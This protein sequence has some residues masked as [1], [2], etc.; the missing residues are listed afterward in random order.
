MHPLDTTANAAPSSPEQNDPNDQQE[1][2]EIR[3]ILK[4]VYDEI[5]RRLPEGRHK[6]LALT[7]I[8]TASLWAVKAIFHR[9]RR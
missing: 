1:S 6:A 2:Q 8:E 7:A 4:P 5:E 9:V 3:E